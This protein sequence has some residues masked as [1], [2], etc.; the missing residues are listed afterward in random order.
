MARFS[1]P[2]T[3]PKIFRDFKQFLA[4]IRKYFRRRAYKWFQYFESGKD[5]LVDLLYKKRGK[6]VRPFLHFGAIGLTFLVITIG[7][8][9]FNQTPEN[10]QEQAQG[11][12]SAQAFGES[13]YTK[14]AEEVQQIR[15]GE[16]IT[17][18]VQEGETISTIA[19]RYNLQVNTL[20]WE[21]GLKEKDP[22][23]P[24]QELRILPVDGV[25]HKVARGETIYSIAKKYKLAEA[26]ASEE[27]NSGAQAIVDYPFNVFLNDETFALATGQELIIPGGIQPQSKLASPGVPAISRYQ[28][29]PA[30]GQVNPTGQFVWP[31]SGKVTQGFF[32]YHRAVDIA[33]RSGGPILAADA[34]TIETAG[35]NAG[36]YG[37]Y[38]VID[39]G[40][41]YKTL[42]GHLSVI[43]IQPG[44]TVNRADVLGQ[45]G[46][47]G[48]STGTHLH[49]E[50][51]SGEA[52]LNPLSFLP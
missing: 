12:L 40:N 32:A 25:R 16:V 2:I 33:N 20:I 17:H 52:L 49:F 7:P 19:E 24:G 13:F 22:I 9:I 47:T 30:A 48:R 38:I 4:Y 11:V 23:K 45:M 41:G 44:Q 46:N 28:Q 5:W 1:V 29:T 10:Q 18:V 35:W 21:N 43:Q 36:G 8:V 31:A 50:I 42:Y 6:Y 14:Q 3:L 15:G 37:N 39:H 27:E 51:R 34:G 26:D